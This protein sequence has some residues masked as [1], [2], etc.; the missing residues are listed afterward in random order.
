MAE[1]IDNDR[2]HEDIHY[3]FDYFSKFINFTSEDISA[4]NMF[5]TSAVSVIPV[6]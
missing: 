5:A 3:R 6:I 1:H 4:L 2:L